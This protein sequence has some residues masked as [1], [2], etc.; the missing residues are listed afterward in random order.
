[1]LE[2]PPPPTEADAPPDAE[3]VVVPIT[4]GRTRNGNGTVQP[5]RT[6]PNDLAAEASLL[7]ALLLSKEGGAADAWPDVR[8]V[9][10]TRMSFY[11]PANGAIYD[12]IAD[13]RDKG[14]EVD[15]VLVAGAVDHAP[16]PDEPNMGAYLTRLVVEC[17]AISNG[18]S[19]ARVVAEKAYRRQLISLAVDLSDAA[20]DIRNDDPVAVLAKVPE[21]ASAAVSMFADLSKTPD[22]LDPPNLCVREDGKVHFIYPGRLHTLIGPSEAGKSW[23]AARWCLQLMEQ[24]QHV[25]YL[26]WEDTDVGH[27]ARLMSMGATSEMLHEFFH[28]AQRDNQWTPAARAELT[29]A[30]DVW[31]PAL[32]VVDAMT[33]A[34]ATEGADDWRGVDIA[35]F[36]AD[37]VRVCKNAGAAVLVIDHV[38]KADETQTGSHYKKGGIDGVSYKLRNAT[39]MGRGRRGLSTLLIEK[40]RHGYLRGL[41]VGD[42]DVIGTLV[43]DDTIRGDTVV[44]VDAPV[45]AVGRSDADGGERYP[46]LMEKISQVVEAA[47][48]GVTRTGVYESVKGNRQKATRALAALLKEGWCVETSGPSLIVSVT[49]FR[50]V[51]AEPAPTDDLGDF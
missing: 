16:P 47:P 30:L 10:L 35:R 33:P 24:G 34:L 39:P 19:Y 36:Y 44:R 46:A 18:A 9:G 2:E 4:N 38:N 23:L 17:P 8:A 27:K 13:L 50:V 51:D 43:V 31:N 32:V 29:R 21:P 25:V 37:V 42:A 1:M 6:P 41:A 45:G 12:T 15:P 22:T 28:Y 49:P 40:D 3:V 7:G 26:D 14:S 11:R 5:V 20:Y 48:G